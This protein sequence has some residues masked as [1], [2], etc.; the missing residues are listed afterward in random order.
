[1]SRF[2]EYNLE[3]TAFERTDMADKRYL[4]AAWLALG[5]LAASGRAATAEDLRLV[6][7][8]KRG[9]VDVVRALIREKIDVNA[10]ARDGATPLH[11][12]AETASVEIASLLTAAG[13]DANATNDFGVTPLSL[14]CKN[15]N[16][17]LVTLLL[18]A[19]ARPN[20]AVRTGETPL[21]TAA[22][23]GRLEVLT[24]LLEAGAD[25]KA[26]EPSAGQTALMWAAAEGHTEIVR[27]LIAR[28][29]NVHEGSKRSF[30][31]LLFA[32][33]N[34]DIETTRVLL[35]AGVDVNEASRDSTTALVIATI[36]SQTAYARFLLERGANPNKGPGFTPLHWVVG[37]WS[38]Q[39]AGEKTRV[40]PEGTEYDRLLPLQGQARLDYAE[41]LLSFGADVNARAT[42]TPRASVGTGRAPAAATSAST[43]RQEKLA[44][45][46]PFFMAAQIADLSMMRF[47]VGHGAQPLLRTERNVSPLMVAAGVDA[48]TYIGFTLVA[49]RDAVEAI[50][51][52]LELGDDVNTVSAYGENALHG[53][54]YRGVAGSN[55]I[56]QLLLDRGINVNL[57]NK[58]GWSP[59]TLAEGIYSNGSN[60]RN[61]EL[62][63][64]L[65]AHGAKPSP[66]GIERDAY[67][68][69]VEPTR[70]R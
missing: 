61:P 41:M 67:A 57:V 27:T 21:M 40:R 28:G 70:D 18:R 11:W 15:G 1:M 43:V 36:R 49:E 59:V 24:A 20:T 7:A 46:T 50:K 55:Q 2:E 38:V 29:A 69:I 60:S 51:L 19:G 34:G 31:P 62:E 30:T 42:S 35:D 48:D 65:L 16:A 4:L 13:A 8:V 58:R 17:A 9:Q 53:A 45:A 37:D 56:A 63:R 47:L 66:P 52:C 26:K 39:L 14:A 25:V 44:G 12:A 6:E 10:P 68:V 3:T 64:L 23:T 5:M 32:A 33:R 22:R 54:G